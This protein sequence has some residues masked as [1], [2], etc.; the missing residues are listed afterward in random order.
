M[1]LKKQ[2]PIFGKMT[3]V[4]R[5]QL[6]IL[7]NNF[8][9]QRLQQLKEK[10]IKGEFLSKPTEKKNRGPADREKKTKLREVYTET[11]NDLTE[12]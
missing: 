6:L 3:I 7:M 11:S 4:S 1:I 5:K 2:K 9:R 8:M 10:T 12:I